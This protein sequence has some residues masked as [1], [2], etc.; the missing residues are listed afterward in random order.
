MLKGT[1]VKNKKTIKTKNYPKKIVFH[2]KEL[3]YLL[4]SVESPQ[5]NFVL[6]TI[7]KE[8][9][10]NG[11]KVKKW[12]FIWGKLENNYYLLEFSNFT[13]WCCHVLYYIVGI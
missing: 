3:N 12:K 10:S 2:K 9:F 8:H 6:R 1:T 13:L 5:I 11:I 4:N 7:Q